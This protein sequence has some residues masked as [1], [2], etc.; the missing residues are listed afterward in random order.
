MRRSWNLI[1]LC[2]FKRVD[3]PC[4][5]VDVASANPSRAGHLLHANSF[6]SRRKSLTISLLDDKLDSD[7]FCASVYAEGRGLLRPE[8]C[9]TEFPVDGCSP[10]SHPDASHFTP[11]SVVVLSYKRPRCEYF[12]TH[13]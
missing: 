6:H 5:L 8:R 10:F 9:C 2:R 11:S 7:T 13:R 1:G 12:K 3:P 4:V